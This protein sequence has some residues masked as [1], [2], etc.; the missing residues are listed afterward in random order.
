MEENKNQ[1]GKEERG[2]KLETDFI[3]IIVKI[4]SETVRLE[5]NAVF[6]DEGGI[7]YNAVMTMNPS[8]IFKARQDF[9]DNVDFGDDYDGYFTLTDKGK[10]MLENDDLDAYIWEDA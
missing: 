2:K 6:L 4:P 5:V 8:D 3:N 7:P 1:T 10:E 9:L